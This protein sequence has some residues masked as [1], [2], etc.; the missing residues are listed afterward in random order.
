MKL[1]KLF[2]DFLILNTLCSYFL[3]VIK[4]LTLFYL[5][6]VSSIYDPSSFFSVVSPGHDQMVTCWAK[7]C[8]AVAQ[9]L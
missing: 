6:Q 7:L 9:A 1:L 8:Q 4:V 3:I 2:N 5:C